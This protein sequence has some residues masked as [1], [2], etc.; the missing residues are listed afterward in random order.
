MLFSRGFQ[1]PLGNTIKDILIATTLPEAYRSDA[2]EE[3]NTLSGNKL[4]K[5]LQGV[6]S[7]KLKMPEKQK[8]LKLL[9]GTTL[10]QRLSDML[11]SID[12]L[13]VLKRAFEVDNGWTEAWSMSDEDRSRV[14]IELESSLAAKQERLL[15]S[16]LHNR[17]FVGSS[18]MHTYGFDK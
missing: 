6:V 4:V 1:P 11:R 5:I 14:Q 8:I 15:A 2:S 18:F 13:S 10:R 9:G 7:M 17:G 12:G 3:I 16:R